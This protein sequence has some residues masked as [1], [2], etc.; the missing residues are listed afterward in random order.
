M[1][2]NLQ[3]TQEQLDA[4]IATKVSEA[5]TGLYTE[6]DLTKK[7][8]SEVDRRVESGIQKG[9]ETKKQKWEIEFAERAKLSAEEIAKKELDD[10]LATFAEREKEI[11]KKANL[12]EAKSLLSEASVPKSHYDK[13]IGMLVSDNEE[14]TKVNVQNF[15]DMF[16]STKS[17][18]ETKVKSEFTNIPKPGANA[19]PGVVTKTEFDK[20]GYADKMK[21]KQSNPEMYKQFIK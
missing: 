1:E 5:K 20:M 11:S 9:L 3:F 10:K 18:I 16:N 17:E 21:F 14:V 7:V 4:L 8:T 19:N 6:E 13:F 2:E 15:I 12:L